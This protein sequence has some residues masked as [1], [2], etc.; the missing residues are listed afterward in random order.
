MWDLRL[1]KLIKKGKT[2]IVLRDVYFNHDGTIGAI[3]DKN[4][5]LES[6]CIKE[7]QEK[8]EF[9]QTHVYGREIVIHDIDSNR[10]YLKQA[11]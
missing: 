6:T 3:S 9:I 5:S 1:I 11:G 10:I 2:K 7:F 8:I 4:Y